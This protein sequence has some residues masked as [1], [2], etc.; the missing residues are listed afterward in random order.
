MSKKSKK[1]VWVVAGVA[2]IA[3]VAG[4]LFWSRKAHAAQQQPPAPPAPSPANYTPLQSAAVDMNNAIDAHGY[5][6]NDVEVYKAFQQAAGI[7]VDGWPGEGTYKALVSTLASIGVAPSA[8][9]NPN[10]TFSATYGFD[11]VHAPLSTTW[12][13]PGYTGDTSIGPVAQAPSG[14][15]GQ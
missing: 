6:A 4:L 7:K 1:T 8:N 5:S 15:V 11:G 3:A 14:P 9:L 12:W 10:Y 13:P 2:G